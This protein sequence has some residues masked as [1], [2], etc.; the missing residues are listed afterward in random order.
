MRPTA[1][2]MEVV[3]TLRDPSPLEMPG[4]TYPSATPTAIA[5]NIHMVRNLLRKESR[6]RVPSAEVLAPPYAVR[7]PSR[8]SA[9]ES[10]AS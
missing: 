3:P 5:T 10:N 8:P 6:L 9:G 4:K 1:I 2:G 7:L